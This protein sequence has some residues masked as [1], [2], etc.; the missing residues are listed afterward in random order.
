MI[1]SACGS[2]EPVF[3][4]IPDHGD[5]PVLELS[6]ELAGGTGGSDL[7]LMVRVRWVLGDTD[8]ALLVIVV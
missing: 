3:L 5:V 1:R 7:R 2:D 6:F 4:H 8:I